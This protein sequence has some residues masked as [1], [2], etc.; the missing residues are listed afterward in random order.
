M[1]NL[2]LDDIEFFNSILERA[3]KP[4]KTNLLQEDPLSQI[5][6]DTNDFRVRVVRESQF[7]GGERNTNHQIYEWPKQEYFD[8]LSQ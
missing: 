1:R 4:N 6:R 7:A 8:S 5:K 3:T 2:T